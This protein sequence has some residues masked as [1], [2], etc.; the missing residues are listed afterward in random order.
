VAY[1]SLF[2][3]LGI[4]HGKKGI[5]ITSTQFIKGFFMLA[6]DLTPGGY[7]SNGFTSL[8]ENGNI[9]IEMKMDWAFTEAITILLYLEFDASI[10]ID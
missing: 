2:T 9:R 10:H 8:P 7:A 1:Q 6:F 5:Q 3:G 4:Y